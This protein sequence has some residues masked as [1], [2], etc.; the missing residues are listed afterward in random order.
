[1]KFKKNIKKT[2]L[3]AKV[4]GGNIGTTRSI[5]YDV[6]KDDKIIGEICQSTYYSWTGVETSFM[7]YDFSRTS[8]RRWEDVESFDSGKK[9]FLDK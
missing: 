8:G 6:I 2:K 1:M 7:I 4:S 5:V 9:Y 3:S